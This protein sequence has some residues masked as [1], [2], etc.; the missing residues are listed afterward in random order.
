MIG[1]AVK[2]GGVRVES[3]VVNGVRVLVYRADDCVIDG[4]SPYVKCACLPAFCKWASD[5]GLRALGYYASRESFWVGDL[6]RQAERRGIK[7]LI[8]HPRTKQPPEWATK[9]GDSLVYLK[10]NIYSVNYNISRSMMREQFGEHGLML[11]M[12]I[13]VPAF[14]H[15]QT[16]FFNKFPVPKAVTYIVPSGSGTALSCLAIALGPIN[17]E[18][19]GIV[20][21]PEKSV[22]RVIDNNTTVMFRPTIKL[23]SLDHQQDNDIDATWPVTKGWERT[24]YAWLK[25]NVH[26]L[27]QPICFLNLGR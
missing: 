26:S 10:P 12:G 15:V 5:Y 25:K 20:T 1:F 22:Q 9:M 23:H 16:A 14:V 18:L 7:A 3:H 21:R 27:A 2:D 24:A 4:F 17:V 13:D 11:P 8:T 6:K 19:H